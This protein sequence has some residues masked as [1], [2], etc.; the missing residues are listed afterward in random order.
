MNKILFWIKNILY[1]ILTLL[2]IKYIS[3]FNVT[4][5]IFFLY[6]IIYGILVVLTIKDILSKN[7]NDMYNFITII[8]I[9]IMS[10][11]FIRTIYDSSFI[12]NNKEMLNKFISLT[13]YDSSGY[14]LNYDFAYHNI[15]YLLQ[16]IPYFILIT[17]LLIIYRTINLSHKKIITLNTDY[18]LLIISI[19]TIFPSIYVLIEYFKFMSDYRY[20]I[21]FSFVYFIIILILLGVITFR[22]IQ[23]KYKNKHWMIYVSIPFYILALIS[24]TLDFLIQFKIWS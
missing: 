24:I 22:Y 18:M 11:I 8:G 6:L 4:S 21:G 16:N 3:I 1:I 12:L 9:G 10:F 5:F 7:N 19:L 23:G 20:S 14:I 2:I 17:I 13:G 15:Y